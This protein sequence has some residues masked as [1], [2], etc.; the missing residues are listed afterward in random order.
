MSGKLS[1]RFSFY[2]FSPVCLSLV[3][4]IFIYIGR[5][6]DELVAHCIK[7]IVEYHAAFESQSVWSTTIG[8]GAEQFVELFH[9]HAFFLLC[10]HSSLLWIFS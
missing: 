2:Y 1:S 4:Q 5:R 9:Y 7:F 3:S 8:A 10:S 6:I